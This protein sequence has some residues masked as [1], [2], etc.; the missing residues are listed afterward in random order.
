MYQYYRKHILCSIIALLVFLPSFPQANKISNKLIFWG[1]SNAFYSTQLSFSLDLINQTLTE[2]PP[3]IKFSLARKLALYNL[4]AIL[5]ETKYDNTKEL[6]HFISSR[7]MRTIK[8]LSSPL[9][10]GIK[11]YK[12]YND[13]FIIHSRSTV[14]AFDLCG[15]LGTI[16]PD[17]LMNLIVNKCDALFISHAHDDHADANVVSMFAKQRKPIFAPTNL[18]ENNTAITHIRSEKVIRTQLKIKTNNIQIRIYPGHQDDLLNNIYVITLPEKM[19]VAQLGDQYN[20]NDMVWLK[21]IYKQIP[22]LDILMVDCW[23]DKMKDIIADFNPK[24]VITGHENEMGHS[25]DHREPFWLTYYKME[26]VKKPYLILG[27]GEW[28][29]YLSSKNL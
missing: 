13:G 14:L 27:W 21:D 17:S 24:L 7:I 4:D 9:K 1:D 28:F 10:T 2:N 26:E 18:W 23:I 15:R 5:H 16:I 20:K 19:T 25:I 12:I 29:H 22:P 11:V 6:H 3:S 8:D